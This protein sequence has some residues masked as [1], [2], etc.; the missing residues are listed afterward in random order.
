MK[1]VGH[2]VAK[3]NADFRLGSLQET[4]HLHDFGIDGRIIL[5]CICLRTDK[6]PALVSMLMNLRAP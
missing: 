1:Q 6:L 2:V 3:R 5:K 4:N